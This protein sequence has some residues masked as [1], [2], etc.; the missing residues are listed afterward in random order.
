MSVSR[1][2][3]FM[4]KKTHFVLIY[5]SFSTNIIHHS[6]IKIKVSL[7]KI[8]FEGVMSV[9]RTRTFINV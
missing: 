3:T 9:S 2:R 7:K 1:T 6:C 5:E 8:L 4:C